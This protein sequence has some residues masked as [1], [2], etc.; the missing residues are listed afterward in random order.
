[1]KSSAA[2]SPAADLITLAHTIGHIT[3]WNMPAASRW[4]EGL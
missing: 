1:M 2:Q 4:P 3:A